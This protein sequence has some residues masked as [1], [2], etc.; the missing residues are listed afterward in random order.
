MEAK[1]AENQDGSVE[2]ERHGQR[3]E[4][5]RAGVHRR[6]DDERDDVVDHDDREHEGAQA[7]REAR[8]DQREQTERERG[9]GRHRDAP[10]V[11]RRTAGVEG[12][13]DGDRGRCASQSR[14]E[15]QREPSPL[16][17]LAEVE[18]PARLEADDEEEERHQPA[19]HPAAQVERD[20]RS[21][22]VDREPRRPDRVVGARVDVHPDQRGGRRREQHGGAARLRA[23]ELPQRRLDAPRPRRPPGEACGHHAHALRSLLLPD[24][25]RALGQS[26][27]ARLVR[28]RGGDVR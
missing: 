25:S 3:H 15:R 5:D 12:E 27:E 23:Q 4:V 2:Q 24:E 16:P 14:D 6:D 1:G 26:P 11:R 21:A 7:I 28:L 18:L 9:V 20:A 8:P 22:Q 17:Q 13:V 19:V 10:A